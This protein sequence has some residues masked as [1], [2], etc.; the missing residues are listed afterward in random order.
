MTATEDL[1]VDNLISPIALAGLFP[2]TPRR[3]G[4]N[5]ADPWYRD[6]GNVVRLAEYLAEVG[7]DAFVV[8][9]ML[10]SPWRFG[11]LWERMRA[12]ERPGGGGS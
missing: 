9:N 10:R 7:E 12:G 5:M 8:V 11:D 6:Y 2:T 3:T 1:P 4:D